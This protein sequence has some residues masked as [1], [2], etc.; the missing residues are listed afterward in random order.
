MGI[1][2]EVKIKNPYY[3]GYITGELNFT[4]KDIDEAVM[5]GIT[6]ANLKTPTD[7]KRHIKRQFLKLLRKVNK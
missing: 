7:L 1:Q 4:E 5:T 2:V 6:F 3:C